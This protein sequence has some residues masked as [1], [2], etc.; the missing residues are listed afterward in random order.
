M[1]FWLHE[2]FSFIV[3]K[4][5]KLPNQS[6]IVNKREGI[7]KKIYGGICVKI[8][9]ELHLIFK[10]YWCFQYFLFASIPIVIKLSPFHSFFRLVIGQSKR[11]E[12]GIQKLSQHVC[13]NLPCFYF[14]I[15]WNEN[16]IGFFSNRQNLTHIYNNNEKLYFLLLF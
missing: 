2:I 13:S 7:V 5:V 8:L 10:V 3:V 16:W 12:N 14:L 1:V 9:V 11:K 15:H 4:F 6:T